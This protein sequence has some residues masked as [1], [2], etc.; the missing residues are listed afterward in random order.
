MKCKTKCSKMRKK[1]F[2]FQHVCSTQYCVLSRWDACFSTIK[3]HTQLERLLR[4]MLQILPFEL[5]DVILQSVPYPTMHNRTTQLSLKCIQL[6][7]HYFAFSS[8][9]VCHLHV[10]CLLPKQSW[11]WCCPSILYHSFVNWWH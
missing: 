8:R 2:I 11:T 10:T 5:W 4:K 7:K 6:N 1:H 9:N 3:F